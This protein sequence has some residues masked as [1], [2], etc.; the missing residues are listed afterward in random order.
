MV[1][2]FLAGRSK[3]LAIQGRTQFSL[4]ESHKLLCVILVLESEVVYAFLAGR[5]KGKQSDKLPLMALQCLDALLRLGRTCE[6]VAELMREGP[7]PVDAGPAE[8]STG[9]CGSETAVANWCSLS[10]L[11]GNVKIKNLDCTLHSCC[12]N[13]GL[14]A[15]PSEEDYKEDQEERND[16]LR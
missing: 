16:Y 12:S 3:E 9:A 14:G 1:H 10:S 15:F 8:A 7:V 13:F 2:A 6:G 5:S 4:V 11:S